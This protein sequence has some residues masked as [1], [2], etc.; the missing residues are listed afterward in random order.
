M[1]RT[2]NHQLTHLAGGT[3][4]ISDLIAREQ[5]RKWERRVINGS[6]VLRWPGITYDGG[7]QMATAPAR[8]ADHRLSHLTDLPKMWTYL[9]FRNP[10]GNHSASHC[11]AISEDS[12]LLAA[13]WEDSEILVW[14]LTDGITVQRVHVGGPVGALAFCANGKRLVAAI[15]TVAIVYDLRSGNAVWS[16][17]GHQERIN[18]L[19]YSRRPSRIVTCSQDGA[20]KMWNADSGAPLCSF[21]LHL[22]IK[23]LVFSPDGSRL[24]AQQHSTV[25]LYDAGDLTVQLASVQSKRGR[26]TSVA[27]APQGDRLFVSDESRTGRIYDS[28]TCKEIIAIEGHSDIISSAAFAPGGRAVATASR[29]CSVSIRSSSTGTETWLLQMKAPINRV[30]Y[31]PNGDFIAAAD[32]SGR[33]GVW[34]AL[35]RRS[36]VFIAEF[37]GPESQAART[38]RIEFLPDSRCLLTATAKGAICLWDVGDVLRVR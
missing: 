10:S 4:S 1:H 34:R 15:D 24:A 3:V 31:S 32:D 14:R 16:L 12:T 26:I 6:D 18:D 28:R 27:F 13:A 17:E 37:Q 36:A 2:K 19:A 23:K 9:E 22:A 8:L 21:D 7:G 38:S 29:D 5:L 25:T 35:S 11:L 33:V 30:G 20:L